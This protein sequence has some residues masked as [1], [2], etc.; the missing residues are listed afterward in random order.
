MFGKSGVALFRISGPDAYKLIKALSIDKTIIPRKATFTKFYDNN[1]EII[2]EGILTYFPAPASF[3]GEDVV[4]LNVHGSIAVINA[5]HAFLEEHFRL[6]E[7]GEFTKRAFMSGKFDLTAAEGISALINAET[8]MQRKQALKQ[9]SGVS[10]DLYE[11]WRKDIISVMALV[12]AFIDFPDENISPSLIEEAKRQ[13]ENLLKSIELYLNDKKKGQKVKD[14]IK[15]AIVGPPN[16][17]KSTLFNYFA[18]K[19]AAIVSP[20]PGTTRDVIELNLN[21]EGFL[22]TIQDTAG[23]HETCSEIEQEGIK[24]THDT[25]AHADI[26]LLMFSCEEIANTTI[27]T[28]KQKVNTDSTLVIHLVSKYDLN[29]QSVLP[30]GID[31]I[32]ISV[33]NKTGLDALH[34]KI[35]DFLREYDSPFESPVITEERHRRALTQASVA[36]KAFTE[37]NQSLEILAENL[38]NAAHQ[39]ATI[40]GTINV[41]EVLDKL[42]SSLCIGK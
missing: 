11:S 28:F 8:S 14:G 1:K 6:A 4:E 36:L 34:T 26:V 21:I 35:L 38:R 29:K 39:I 10:R 20:I 7:R 25:I 33:H 9:I 32:P 41:E 23:V 19:N 37:F 24:R 31:F 15:I 27:E 30:D 18:N 22:V 13:I 3:T 12:E 17:G 16:V 2:D 42:F 40:T 5:M